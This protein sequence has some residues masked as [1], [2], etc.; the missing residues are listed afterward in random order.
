MVKLED[1]PKTAFW[2]GNQ[3]YR[4][5]RMPFGLRNSIAHFQRI[6]NVELIEAGLTAS[7][8]SFINSLV[9]YSKTLEKHLV[10]VD[11]CLNVS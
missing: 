4:Y 6:M 2:W 8:S 11:R 1:R 9:I 7:A 10:H 3:L 5:D